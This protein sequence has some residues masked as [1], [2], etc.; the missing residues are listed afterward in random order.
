MPHTNGRYQQALGFN[1]ASIFIGAEQAINT[2]DAGTVTRTAEGNYNLSWVNNK[3]PVLAWNVL[4]YLVTRLGFSP[5]PDLQEQFGGTGVPADA[6]PQ[7]YPSGGDGFYTAGAAL[8]PITPRR[9][10][11]LKGIKLSS[12][13]LV[14]QVGTNNLQLNTCCMDKTVFV[15]GVAPA[16]TNVLASAANGLSAVASAT[17]Y[18]IDVAVP[19]A[20]QVYNITDLQQFWFETALTSGAAGGST[21]VVWGIRVRASF[22]F[23]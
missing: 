1:D 13:G 9:V 15:N 8:Q 17:P 11:R 23:N 10:P 3:A 4:D 18:V 7:G 5:D 6:Y 19:A 20:F 22:N 14:Y 16:I 12:I 21:L 2:G